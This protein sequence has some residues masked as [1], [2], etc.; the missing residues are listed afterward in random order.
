MIVACRQYCDR[1]NEYPSIAYFA[2]NQS[3]SRT[4]SKKVLDFLQGKIVSF[5]EPKKTKDKRQYGKYTLNEEDRSFLIHVYQNDPKTPIS[6][7]CNLLYMYNG[8]RVSRSTLCRVLKYTFAYK[9]SMRKTS[10]FPHKKYTLHN[11]YKINNYINFVSNLNPNRL[12]FTDEKPL[13][14]NEIFRGRVRRD[15]ITGET[16]Q[17]ESSIKLKNN[18]NLMAAVRVNGETDSQNIFY[19]VGKY[20]ADSY[21]FKQFVL[22][23]VRT[24]FLQHGHVLVCDNATVHTRRECEHLREELYSYTGVYMLLLPPYHPELNPIELVFNLL[25]QR[26]RHSTARYV[27]YVNEQDRKILEI[28]CSV[29]NE[30]TTDEIKQMYNSCGYLIN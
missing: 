21:M 17:V 24:N 10:I 27:D 1:Y 2:R 11:L 6:E 25:T 23:M 15:P 5:H 7:Y 3:V 9:T 16:P 22:S 29:L 26:L 20:T 28:C 18:F 12:V 13:Q 30:T 4:T 14:G 8:K 19:Q